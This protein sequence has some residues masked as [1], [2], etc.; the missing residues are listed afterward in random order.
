MKGPNKIRNERG[1]KTIDT[2]E[3]QNHK[4]MNN[5]LDNLEETDKFP[6]IYNPF[7]KPRLGRNR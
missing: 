7:S 6:E 3:I 2:T 4:T 5:K 1:A